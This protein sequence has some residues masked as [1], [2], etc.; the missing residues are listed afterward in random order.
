[1][2]DIE[3][4][5]EKT[6]SALLQLELKEE[7]SSLNEDYRT[8]IELYY[9]VGMNIKEIGELLKEPEGTIKSRLSRAKAI[10][11]INHDKQKGVIGFEQRI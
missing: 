3:S 5:Q 1:M 8:A 6:D 7:L 10:L 2:V 9:I 4:I 11:R